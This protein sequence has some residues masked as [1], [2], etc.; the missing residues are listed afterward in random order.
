MSMGND[1]FVR[2]WV[3]SESLSEVS[4]RTG[5]DKQSCSAKA[6][7]LR[8]IGVNVPE[9]S[10]GRKALSAEDIKALNDIINNS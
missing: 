7:S 10:K 2:I 3:T 6:S 8:K 4:E 5:M 1:T 9:F